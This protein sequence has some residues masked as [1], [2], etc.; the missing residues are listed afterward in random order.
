MVE[1]VKDTFEVEIMGS[2]SFEFLLILP[3]QQK[4]SDTNLRFRLIA[5]MPTWRPQERCPWTILIA[6]L[7]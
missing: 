6:S 5:Y 4:A 7:K 1:N 2:V 3:Q